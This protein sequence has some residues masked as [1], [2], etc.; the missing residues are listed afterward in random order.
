MDQSVAIF[1][2]GCFWCL[3]AVFE[4]LRGV[5]G[6]TSGY[7]GGDDPDPAYER[8]CQGRTGHAEVVRIVFDPGIISFEA[9]LE[10]FFLIHDPTTPDRQGADIGTQY[11][12]VVFC[13]DP[14]QEAAAR[15]MIARLEASGDLPGPVVTQVA[16]GAR[17]FPAEDH[18]QDYFRANPLAPYCRAVVA[19]KVEKLLKTH[20]E[21]V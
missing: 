19:P 11:R 14:G 2:G 21:W 10:V 7:A 9:L 16:P 5:S 18:H 6:V 13:H 1:G 4:R 3:E 15:A 12:S 20:P 17:F 8:V